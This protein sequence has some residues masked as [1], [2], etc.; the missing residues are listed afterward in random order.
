MIAEG[1]LAVTEFVEENRIENDDFIGTKFLPRVLK[2]PKIR[3]R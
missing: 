2:H 3:L 1:W